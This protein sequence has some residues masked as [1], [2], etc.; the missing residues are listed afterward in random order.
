MLASVLVLVLAVAAPAAPPLLSLVAGDGEIGGTIQ[1]TATLSG[2]PDATGEIV[3][4]VFG[5]GDASCSTTGQA[6][7][8]KPVSGEGEYVSAAFAPTAAGVYS[9]S[10]HYSGDE[11]ADSLCATSNVAKAS[12]TLT[13]SASAATAG[14]TIHDEASLSGGFTP[15][16]ELTFSVY[17]PTDTGCSTPLATGSATLQGGAARSADYLPSQAGEFRWTAAYPG[18]ANNEAASTS[19]NL[20]GQTS[21]VAKA[22]P[23]LSGLATSAVVVGQPITDAVTVSAGFAAGG[24]LL[25]RAYGPADPDCS[26]APAY[27]Q[28]VSVNG[29][30]TYAPAGFAPGPGLYRWTVGYGGDANNE[31]AD[32]ACGAGNQA[33]AVGTIAVTLKV[34][35]SGGTVGSPVAATATI[36]EG[37]T[38]GGQITFKAFPPADATC[39]GAP[40]FSST[41][42]VAGNGTYTS[43]PFVPARVGSFRW[44]VDYSGD[45]NHAAASSSCGAA[46][47][48]VTRAVPSI[49]GWTKKRITLGDSVQ[50]T[51]ALQGAQAPT[52]TVT[53]RVYGPNTVG[54]AKPLLV[55]TVAISG[56]G[57][58]KSAPFAPQRPGRY[59]FLASYSGDAANA[60]A[61]EG[62]ESALQSVVVKKR[63]PR[64]TPRAQLNGSRQIS[65]LARLAGAFSPSGRIEFRLYRPGDRL[66]RLRPALSGSTSV[67]RNGTHS[68][69]EYLATRGGVYRL[70]V[71]YTGDLR[72]DRFA[73]SCRQAQPIRVAP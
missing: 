72:N 70:V 46:A 65:I 29:D 45:P 53:F 49:L 27:E 55:N 12:P 73:A 40:A 61:A 9:W 37:A 15:T 51:A 56:S 57:P 62:C 44:S 54:C 3:F 35:A 31:A 52:G 43:G 50:D 22:S 41:A 4:D 11:P 24:E 64:V 16:G 30:G 34:S 32:L 20:A 38:P 42:A 18:D 8:P 66:C 17:A 1:A 39:A 67:T 58:L 25:F 48:A 36:A 13:G 23:T 59:S 5:P 63:R 26:G 71:G 2:S 7:E 28:A 6:L 68:L 60:A 19:C 21:V 33:S 69:A 10:A 47:S 14:A